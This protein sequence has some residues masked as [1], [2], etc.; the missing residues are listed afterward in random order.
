[1][2]GDFC[3]SGFRLR[4]LSRFG[5]GLCRFR[6][7]LV[8]LYRLLGCVVD[9]WVASK[10]SGSVL[11][12][13]CTRG[14]VVFL[15]SKLLLRCNISDH[16]SSSCLSACVELSCCVIRCGSL[17]LVFFCWGFDPGVE[18]HCCLNFVGEVS[19]CS[20]AGGC[21]SVDVDL[22]QLHGSSSCHIASARIRHFAATRTR[23]LDAVRLYLFGD[24]LCTGVGCLL[25]IGPRTCS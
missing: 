13:F 10:F 24:G 1:M 23:F 25:S 3:D 17:E 2:G 15:D 18:R 4:L 6:S 8:R 19:H 16:P 9:R 21:R 11:D 7:F 14:C 22:S 5:V 12:L 20:V